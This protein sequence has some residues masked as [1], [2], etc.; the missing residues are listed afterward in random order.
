[1]KTIIPNSELINNILGK[2]KIN[3]SLKYRPIKFLIKTRYDHTELIYNTLTK[4]LISLTIE[5]NYINNKEIIY[6]EKLNIL[7][8]NWFLVP[9]EYDELKV[10]NQV[11][12]MAK[13]LLKNDCIND[14][15]ILPTTVCNAR[16]FYCFEAGKKTYTMTEEIAK[17]VVQYILNVSKGQKIKL[18][19]F[20]GEPLCNVK[21]INIIT[22]IIKSQ[23]IEFDSFMVSNGYN[24]SEKLINTAINNWNLSEIQISLDGT[25]SVYN[26]I[27]NYIN[28]EE[29]PFA[30]VI[31]NIENLL[32]NNVKVNI[33]LNVDKYNIQNIRELVMFLASRF[34]R[35]SDKLYIYSSLL[36][37]KENASLNP[38]SSAERSEIINEILKLEDY[39]YSKGLSTKSKPSSNLILNHCK[40]DNIN[41]V[42]ILPN[43]DLG[44]CE[45][46]IEDEILGSIY[47]DRIN[48]EVKK[49]WIDYYKSSD[50]CDKCAYLP[51]CINLSKC[52][53]DEKVP[54]DDSLQKL[55]TRKLIRQIQNVYKEFINKVKI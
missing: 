37:D 21:A 24:F 33:R 6:D 11:R 29:N 42:I 2:Q 32:K 3:T 7:I 51:N 47:C 35:Y 39:L 13:M 5:E 30:K 9:L 15:T 4:Q 23:N 31:D 43:G 14:F 52:P 45:H 44:V 18:E 27:K 49:S 17:D 20:G 50:L 48:A 54:C 8:E 34:Q 28:P 40:A 22:E 12:T 41:S 38:H 53:S 26:K 1:M 46:H 55:K 10:L 16:C 25:E 36:H 19:W